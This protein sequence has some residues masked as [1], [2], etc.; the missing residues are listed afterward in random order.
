VEAE[1]MIPW[2]FK[3][4]VSMTYTLL[5]YLI[6]ILLGEIYLK[7]RELV[8]GASF[9]PLFFIIFSIGTIILMKVDWVTGLLNLFFGMGLP[10][11]G[12]YFALF[13]STQQYLTVLGVMVLAYTAVL[14]LL[15]FIRSIFSIEDRRERR[16]PKGEPTPVS[17]VK[18]VASPRPIVKPPRMP[19]K[20]AGIVR[21]V[22]A[23]PKRV[24]CIPICILLILA[25]FI[26]A[27]LKLNWASWIPAII[28]LFMAWVYILIISPLSALFV[29]FMWFSLGVA[30]L[31]GLLTYIQV[32][33]ILLTGLATYVLALPLIFKLTGRWKVPS[34]PASQMRP[35]IESVINKI[36]EA[37]V[38]VKK[39][40]YPR[41]KAIR[42]PPPEEKQRRFKEVWER[43][44]R[45]EYTTNLV[46]IYS[47]SGLRLIDDSHEVGKFLL[48]LYH[49]R[50]LLSSSI[51]EAILT[52]VPGEGSKNIFH[53]RVGGREC[54]VEDTGRGMEN[55]IVGRLRGILPFNNMKLVFEYEV[56]I[57]DVRRAI[58]EARQA[59]SSSLPITKRIVGIVHR[60]LIPAELKMLR[61]ADYIHYKYPSTIPEGLH[62]LLYGKAL[63]RALVKLVR[64]K[65][66]QEALQTYIEVVRSDRLFEVLC[67]MHDGAQFMDRLYEAGLKALQLFMETEI[68]KE[69]GSRFI[70]P[71][72][73]IIVIEDE[74]GVY[75][76]PDFKSM[77]NKVIYDVKT[78][79][80]QT[81]P[82][83]AVERVREQMRVFQLAYPHS[84]ATLMFIP[85]GCEEISRIELEP[86]TYGEVEGQLLELWKACMEKG[87][88]ET[89][90]D[91]KYT[92]VRY[93]RYEGEEPGIY[94]EVNMKRLRSPAK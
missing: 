94:F 70:V 32:V 92:I 1:N 22:R 90:G 18:V 29:L 58:S 52:R 71:W 62:L 41:A 46:G 6:P 78:I 20:K 74:V 25:P 64:S 55:R 85:Y 50:L 59:G 51:I 12:S 54:L 23:L 88:V 81:S 66:I 76:Q 17:Q 28:M 43:T 35:Q 47:S 84:K 69:Y 24:L 42:I 34:T 31:H 40:P 77:D 49:P 75:A 5:S 36:Q 7:G 30:V 16:Y 39:T 67:K 3:P 53:V 38:K 11:I 45:Y 37:E 83:E 48:N 27:L 21:K 80:P 60:G 9:T 61:T 57:R 2:R 44:D 56:N 89:L 15:F 63:H 14:F 93:T 65:S 33:A 86:L 91:G 19:E 13:S 8:K 87:I 79:D 4:L 10:Y 72:S 73:R 68:Y 26:L 82:Q